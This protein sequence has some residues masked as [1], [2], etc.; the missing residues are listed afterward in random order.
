LSSVQEN[1]YQLEL[2]LLNSIIPI[3]TYFLVH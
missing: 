1:T 2:H 3:D